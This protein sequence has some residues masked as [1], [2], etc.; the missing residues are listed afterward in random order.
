ME[1]QLTCNNGHI[2]ES[3]YDKCPYC[4]GQGADATVVEGD[5]DHTA[6]TEIM[7]NLLVES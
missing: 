6:K 1:D 2:Y 7:E 5:L 3:S 4:P